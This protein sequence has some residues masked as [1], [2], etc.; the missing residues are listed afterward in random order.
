MI[1][2]HHKTI[3][4]HIPK[5]A[6]QS[7]ETAFLDHLGLTWDSRAA[8]LLRPNTDPSVGPP[9]LAHLFASEYLSGGHTTHTEF[10]AYFK[11]AIVRNP[12]ARLLS[13]FRYRAPR[14]TSFSKFIFEKFPKPGF[15]DQFRHIEPQW[16]Y[17]YN[18]QGASLVDYVGKFENL[19]EDFEAI[20]GRANLPSNASLPMVNTTNNSSSSDYRPFYNSETRAFVEQYYERD[21]QLFGYTF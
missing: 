21:I 14:K 11:F 20:R 2:H 1:S 3:F 8:L 5:T 6:G 18:D 17:I 15:Q 9:R 7:I 13:E 16:K 12:W 4:I 19:N 10:N